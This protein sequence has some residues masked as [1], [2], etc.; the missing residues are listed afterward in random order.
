MSYYSDGWDHYL[1]GIEAIKG[2][3]KQKDLLTKAVQTLQEHIGDDR[4]SKSSE[5]NHGL[6]WELRIISGATSDGFLVIWGDAISAVEEA[7][8]FKSMLNKIRRHDLFYSSIAE[9]EIA[10]RLARNGCRI[11]LEPEVGSKR[12][13]MLCQNEKSRFYLEVKTLATA[14]ETAKAMKTTTG[15][16]NACRRTRSGL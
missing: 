14:S 16:L 3:K 2:Y 15:I 11:E 9:L 8:G 6:L 10:G 5:T 12:P 4:P 7:N 1:S 13:D